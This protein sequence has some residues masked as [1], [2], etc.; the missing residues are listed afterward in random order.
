VRQILYNLISNA[1]KFTQAGEIRVRV[2]SD[3]PGLRLSVADTGMGIAPARLKDLFQKF[4]QADTSTTRRFG[5]TG[6]GLAI[7]RELA[8]LMGGA[9]AAQ[10]AEGQGSCFIVELPLERV[11]DSL[12]EP[13]A[14]RPP[15]APACLRVLA[16]EDNAVNRLVIRTL[17]EQAGVACTLVDDGLQAVRAWAREPWDLILMDVQMPLMDGVDAAREIRRREALA[18]RPRTP[19]IALT[20]NAMAHQAADYRAAGMDAIV[21][22]PI[23]IGQ[24]LATLQ[25][26]LTPPP[27]GAEAAA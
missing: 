26:V 11:G 25:Q 14:A 22:K 9:I 19:I 21:A 20:A 5:G 4:T 15:Q 27:A 1:L 3:E 10:S 17:L 24:L 16:A 2:A 18:G 6:L 12:A 13:P 8:E 7:C 23:D